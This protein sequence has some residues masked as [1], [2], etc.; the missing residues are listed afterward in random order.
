MH[1]DCHLRIVLKN[2]F[3]TLNVMCSLCSL[4][5]IQF[6]RVDKTKLSSIVGE[7]ASLTEDQAGFGPAV[8]SASA[9]SSAAASKPASVRSAP[10]KALVGPMLPPVSDITQSDLNTICCSEQD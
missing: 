3:A 10:V 8:P 2:Y 6:S 5:C 1:S 9:S 4:S 7:V